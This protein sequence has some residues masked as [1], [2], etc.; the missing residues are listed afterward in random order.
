LAGA[1]L[2]PSVHNALVS[3]THG[4]LRGNHFLD[5]GLL[6]DGTTT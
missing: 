5:L 6:G 3:R 4:G 1:E 2:V